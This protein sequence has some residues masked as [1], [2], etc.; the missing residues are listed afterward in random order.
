MKS[1]L[2]ST[3]F[4]LFCLSWRELRM[5]ILFTHEVSPSKVY[6]QHPQKYHERS[7][8]HESLFH[9]FSVWHIHNYE[10]ICKG[11]HTQTFL[12]LIETHIFKGKK[13]GSVCRR[14]ISNDVIRTGGEIRR[15]KYRM[16]SNESFMVT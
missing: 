12:R 10:R 13:I 6:Q 4:I 9:H 14:H 7:K 15:R 1:V 2:R 3:F 8:F 5:F 16:I 11:S